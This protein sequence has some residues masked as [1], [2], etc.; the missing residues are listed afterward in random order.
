MRIAAL[1]LLLLASPAWSAWKGV[2]EDDR[3]VTYADPAS[4]KRQGNLA[5]MSHLIDYKGFQRMVEV[6]YFSRKAEAEYDCTGKQVR[7]LGLFLH[8]DR[9]GAGKVIYEDTSPH[10]WEPVQPDTPVEAL[11]SMACKGLAR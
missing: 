6:G 9:M 5:T 1:L 11:W 4:V 7:S 10:D 2:A 8:E 3:A